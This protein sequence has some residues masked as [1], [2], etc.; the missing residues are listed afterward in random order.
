MIREREGQAGFSCLLRHPAQ[1]Q[2]G[3]ILTTPE[4]T[5]DIRISGG[6]SDTQLMQI[7]LEARLLK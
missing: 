7:Y 2:S 6:Q 5:E 3:S 4:P 1:K